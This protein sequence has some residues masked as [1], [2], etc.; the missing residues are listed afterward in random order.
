MT[1]SKRLRRGT[2]AMAALLAGCALPTSPDD[3]PVM[4]APAAWATLQA[5]PTSGQWV[6]PTDA[7][8][9]RLQERALAVNR[10]IAQALLRWQAAQR[11][12][13]MA[14]LARQPTPALDAAAGATRALDGDAPLQRSVSVNLG[15]SYE[16][17]LWQ[18]LAHAQ[19]AAS[20]QA[21]A[22][23]A[24]WAA[25]RVLVRARVAEAWWT[26]AVTTAQAPGLALQIDG[27]EQAVALTRLRVREGKLLPIEIDKA[28]A[29]LQGLRLQAAQQAE[30]A[31][32]Q[33][34]QLGLLLADPAFVP[35]PAPALPSQPPADWRA[36]ESPEQVLARRP[37][38][39]Q[40]RAALDAALQRLRGAEAARYPQLRFDLAL[41]TGGTRW[42]EWLEHP[43]ARLGSTLLVPMIDWRRL[44]LQR[45]DAQ[46]EHEVAALALRD[47]M[48]RALVEIEQLAAEQARLQE[49]EAAQARR[50]AE[51]RTGERLAELRLAVGAISR[52]DWLQARNAR[53]AAEQDTQQLGLRRVLNAVALQRALVAG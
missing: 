46:G 45:L 21:R 37:D 7:A 50:L 27:A 42:S 9:E 36:S 48:H 3:A 14:G 23:E 34:L 44:D 35:P 17:D 32:R 4:A 1:M 11:Q 5:T 41:G 51:A 2:W 8:L 13:R 33:R 12:D 15:A 39:Q 30:L 28:A 24:D 43:L 49:E 25:A 16:V 10:D 22:A 53:L 29:T 52:L 47:A 31:T 26:L 18:R 40:A 19:Q 20:A 38:V 6:G